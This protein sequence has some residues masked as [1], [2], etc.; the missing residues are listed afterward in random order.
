MCTRQENKPSRASLF[1]VKTVWVIIV[2]K[3]FFQR[4]CDVIKSVTFCDRIWPF[5]RG[6]KEI[7]ILVS[8]VA[9]ELVFT[10]SHSKCFPIYIGW[11]P[12]P[13]YVNC[14]EFNSILRDIVGFLY[15]L[16]Y[17]DQNTVIY[18]LFLWC[19]LIFVWQNPWHLIWSYR[20]FK[21]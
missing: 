15:L 21:T 12:F 17:Y 18:G 16:S 5:I 6:K 4:S 9:I 13:I 8:I 11:R 2:I 19:N 3:F 7:W 1:S 20:S 14:N 10:V